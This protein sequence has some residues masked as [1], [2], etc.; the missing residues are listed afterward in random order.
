MGFGG[1]AIGGPFFSPDGDP[2]G[3]GE[4][5]DG[6]SIAAI[7]TAFDAGITLYDTANVYGT[8]RSERVLAQALAGKRDQ[9]VLATK[10]GNTMVEMYTLQRFLDPQGLSD[11]GIEHFD[12][13]A[14]TFGEVVDTMEISP[15]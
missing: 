8:G 2:F 1:W 15:D 4:V 5:D 14:A 6:E 13:W 11:R 9:V 3:W 10:W 7:R 12:A